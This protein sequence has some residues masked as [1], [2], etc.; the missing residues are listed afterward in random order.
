MCDHLITGEGFAWRKRTMRNETNE[1]FDGYRAGDIDRDQPMVSETRS[2]SQRE[3]E[4]AQRSMKGAQKK[5]VD[6]YNSADSQ[7]RMYECIWRLNN[8]R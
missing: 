6:P 4:M 7:A 2:M 1:D 3:I 8:Y 5:G